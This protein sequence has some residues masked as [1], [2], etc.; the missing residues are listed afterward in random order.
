M[1]KFF[2][3]ALLVS[4]AVHADKKL[5]AVKD[6]VMK[7]GTERTWVTDRGMVE[8][9]MPFINLDCA[10]THKDLSEDHTIL[11]GTELSLRRVSDPVKLEVLQMS[12]DERKNSYAFQT[13]NKMPEALNDPK[14]FQEAITEI[15]NKFY[16]DAIGMAF[17][18][19]V[20][21]I[22]RAFLFLEDEK[23]H[24]AYVVQ[25]ENK[26]NEFESGHILDV[27]DTSDI[28]NGVK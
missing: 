13:G 16:G 12:E 28:L 4:S 8:R 15:Y 10:I 1:F 7:T 9:A 19:T 24:D 18:G 25:C 6:I 5:I 20:T 22:I 3:S 2:F 21:D 11:K 23:T 27:L 14:Q 17:D 26:I